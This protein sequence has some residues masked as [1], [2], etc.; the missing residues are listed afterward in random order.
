MAMPLAMGR[1][2]AFRTGRLRG[3]PAG[4][5]LPVGN[6]NATQLQRVGKV[7]AIVGAVLPLLLIGGL[8]LRDPK[9]RP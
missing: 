1:N 7:I 2:G 6:M 8:N 4:E 9:W 5:T 3:S